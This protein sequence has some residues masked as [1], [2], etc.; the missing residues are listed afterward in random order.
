MLEGDPPSLLMLVAL[1][2]FHNQVGAIVG[3]A[4]IVQKVLEQERST[5][6]LALAKTLRVNRRHLRAVVHPDYDAIH[7]IRRRRRK[8]NQVEDARRLWLRS[9]LI[10]LVSQFEAY[11]A[12]TVKCIIEGKPE[13]IDASERKYTYAQ[14]KT[15]KTLDD[16]R[17]SAIESEVESVMRQPRPEKFKWL[18]RHIGLKVEKERELWG[19]FVEA[20]ERRHCLAHSDGRVSDQYIGNCEEA[21]LKWGDVF[22]NGR[23]KHGSLLGVSTGYLGGSCATFDEMSTKLTHFA[24]RVV[25]KDDLPILDN[26]LNASCIYDHL[27]RRNFKIAK[28][29]ALYALGLPRH[30]S[31]EAKLMFIVNLAIAQKQLGEDK[32]WREL[33]GSKEWDVYEDRFKLARAALQENE[34]ESVRIMKKIGAADDPGKHA[35]RTWP[36]FEWMRKKEGFRSAF[37]FIFGEPLV[38]HSDAV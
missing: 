19:A 3:T 9:Q 29:I 32:E 25:F 31:Q 1:D 22:K 16:A 8:L 20:T 26:H 18:E 33:V 24:G 7:S 4:K 38:P 15:F 17:K 5:A 27:E 13:I 35:Y 10:L 12:R 37:E 21:G 23:P 2:R 6:R 14:L 36:L 34:D 28:R 30:S 11:L